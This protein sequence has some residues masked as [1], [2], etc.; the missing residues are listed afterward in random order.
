MINLH[1]LIDSKKLVVAHLANKSNRFLGFTNRAT[2]VH[3]IKS[4]VYSFSLFKTES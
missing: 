3:S 1:T 4:L 2:L